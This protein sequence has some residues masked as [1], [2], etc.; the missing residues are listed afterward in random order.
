VLDRPASADADIQCKAKPVRVHFRGRAHTV[1][2][3]HRGRVTIDFW[4]GR[5][6]DGTP[7]LSSFS[8]TARATVRPR[9][10]VAE[11]EKDITWFEIAAR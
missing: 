10:S 8:G 9:H 2:N 7:D 6:D 4:V 1:I 11:E 3:P 5:P